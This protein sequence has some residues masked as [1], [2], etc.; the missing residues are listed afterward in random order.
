MGKLPNYK[1]LWLLLQKKKITLQNTSD[2]I[3]HA[4]QTDS[5]KACQYLL[6]LCSSQ[7][8]F[9]LQMRARQ[10]NQDAQDI[11]KGAWRVSRDSGGVVCIT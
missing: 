4:F 7:H 1:Y 10:S 5:S 6:H 11:G 2:G 3:K 8:K 9:Q